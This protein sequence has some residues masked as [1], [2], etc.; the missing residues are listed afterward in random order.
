MSQTFI[1]PLVNASEKSIQRKCLAFH[2]I[3]VYKYFNGL[4]A[5]IMNYISKFRKNTYN[6]RK[7]QLFESQNPRTK[8]YGQDCIAYRASQIWQTFPIEIR[9]SISLKIFKQNKNMVL[10]LVP[11]LLLQALHSL[12]WIYLNVTITLYIFSGGLTYANILEHLNLILHQRQ[13]ANTFDLV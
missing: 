3:E 4:S 9:D 11:M 12:L 5:Q 2:M 1:I 7:V 8:R 10:Q 13:C 6:L